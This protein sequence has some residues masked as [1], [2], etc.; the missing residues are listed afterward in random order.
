MRS[1][2]PRYPV[3]STTSG[4]QPVGLTGRRV[5]PT[6]RRNACLRRHDAYGALYETVNID[7]TVYHDVRKHVNKMD[8]CGSVN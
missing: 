3:N 6:T 1:E 4:F 5:E 7:A 8:Y 2:I